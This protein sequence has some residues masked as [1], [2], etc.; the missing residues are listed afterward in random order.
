M[1]ADT[2]WDIER[3]TKLL[4]DLGSQ[5]DEIERSKDNL[6][7][8]N[9]LVNQY[10]QGYAGRNFDSRMDID[11]DNLEYFLKCMEELLNDLKRVISECYETAEDDIRLQLDILRKMMI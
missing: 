7:N 3:L 1:A 5:K 8:L 6:I 11:I 4:G 9:S 10:W 2:K